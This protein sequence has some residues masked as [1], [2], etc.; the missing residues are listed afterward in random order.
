MVILQL[1][2]THR[3]LARVVF[4]PFVYD[5]PRIKVDK[6]DSILSNAHWAL[7]E[8]IAIGH[9]LS[10]LEEDDIHAM[11]DKVQDVFGGR[12]DGRLAMQYA[13]Y[14]LCAQ[15][16]CS[17]HISVFDAGNDLIH[18]SLTKV[19]E[20]A[21]V[22]HVTVDGV[23]QHFSQVIAPS[24]QQWQV[25]DSGEEKMGSGDLGKLLTKAGSIALESSQKISE[26]Y[27]KKVYTL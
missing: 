23:W 24:I 8:A 27:L 6:L 21:G 18:N 2:L 20:K 9:W 5:A 3:F 10:A 13:L 14:T 17:I 26:V 7:P 16:V 22:K 25:E 4:V 15:R 12:L 11:V 19:A 1:F